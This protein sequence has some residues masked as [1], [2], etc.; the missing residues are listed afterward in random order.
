MGERPWRLYAPGR[1]GDRDA[2][3]AAD[4]DAQLAKRCVGLLQDNDRMRRGQHQGDLDEQHL[5]HLRRHDRRVEPRI[6]LELVSHERLVRLYAPVEL[7]RFFDIELGDTGIDR[8]GVRALGEKVSGLLLA[9][10]LAGLAGPF[11]LG[12]PFW[13]FWLG[14]L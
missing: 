2:L 6:G 12:R 13:A 9:G 4:G 3:G 5:G 7:D 11:E 1:V 14:R 8:P 10:R